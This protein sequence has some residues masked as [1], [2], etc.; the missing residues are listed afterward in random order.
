MADKEEKKPPARLGGL[1]KAPGAR[2][3]A[4]GCV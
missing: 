4:L 1:N 3:G 2:L